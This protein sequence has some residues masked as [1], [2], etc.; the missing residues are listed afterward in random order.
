MS[1]DTIR[2]VL[3]YSDIAGYEITDTKIRGWEFYLIRHKLDQNRVKDVEHIQVKV[4]RSLED[5]KYLG[6]AKTEI[7]PTAGKEEIK[8][9]IERLSLQAS[10]VKNPSYTLNNRV[11]FLEAEAKPVDVSSIA[12]DFMEAAKAVPETGTEDI[13][14]YEIFVNEI[15][16]RIINSEGID[17][18]VKYPDSMM[19]VVVNARRDGHEIELY[20]MYHSGTCDK[21]SLVHDITE[22]MKFGKDRLLCEPTPK[23]G[24]YAVLFSTDAVLSIYRNYYLERMSAGYKF[25]GY[26]D[27]EIGKPVT[28][29]A[30]GD[31]VTLYALHEL[32]NSSRN[33]LFDEEGAL[34]RDRCLI[35]NNIP[36]TFFGSRQFSQYL[37]LE[38]SSLVYNYS[39]EGG[40]KSAAELRKGDYLEV[41]EF[42]DFQCDAI[43]GDIAGEIRLA[44]WHHD[45]VTTPVSGGSVSGS[46]KDLSKHMYLSKETRQY[47]TAVVPAVT[48]LEGVKITGVK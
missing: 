6:S 29:D 25:M 8:A 42:S 40:S 3:E 4:F 13:N 46:M 26:S 19:E 14:S 24:T 32:P 7:S 45:G 22:T 39:V 36:E 2:E 48:R 10:Y 27:F 41:V 44:Y 11:N 35:R 17:Y 34:I 18:T 38:H 5:G 37:N 16:R 9:A 47:D 23:L 33:F 1:V 30:E 31:K 28:Q 21:A 43:T 15:E 20:R 12:K